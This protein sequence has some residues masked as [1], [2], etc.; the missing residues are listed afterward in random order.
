MQDRSEEFAAFIG[1][2]WADK[3]HDVCLS[4]PGQPTEACVLEHRP[5]AIAK[6]AAEL[7]ERFAG[8]AIAVCIELSQGP[9]VS[10]LLEHDQFVIFPVNPSTLAKYRRAFTPSRAKDDPTDA[11]VALDILLRHRDKLK[12]LRRE[13]ADVRAL[14]HLVEARRD[15]VHDR[16][17]VTNRLTF[18]LKAYFPQVLTWFRDKETSVFVDFLSKWPSLKHAQRARRD[19]IV[20]FFHSHN[21]RHVA[22][23][24]R[25]LEAIESETPLTTDPGVVEPAMVVVQALLP[26]LRALNAAVEKLDRT[27]L[28]WTPEKRQSASRSGPWRSGSEGRLRMSSRR[29]PCSS[30]GTAASRSRR[31]PETST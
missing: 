25:R 12:P 17:R 3:K 30:S 18:A 4:V 14:R 5:A 2:D 28:Q 8:R 26:Q 27:P 29:R 11:Q 21:V 20:E 19:T 7:R 13:S 6:W 10:A 1:I 22:T 23:I 9:I 24:E 16:V 31:S 15:L